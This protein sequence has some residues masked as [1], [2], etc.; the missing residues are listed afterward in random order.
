MSLRHSWPLEKSSITGS[1]D[2]RTFRHYNV[3][4]LKA[5]CLPIVRENWAIVETVKTEETSRARQLLD[6]FCS[7]YHV[8]I[9]QWVNWSK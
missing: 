6:A 3:G 7:H 9:A 5:R 8:I 2:E 1:R 4:F